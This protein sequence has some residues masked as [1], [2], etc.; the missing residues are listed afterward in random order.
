MEIS[1][2]LIGVIILLLIA[3]PVGYMIIS[4]G[5]VNKKVKKSVVQLSQSNG[6]QLKDID[7]IGNLVIG[8]DAI[9]RKLVYT[10]KKNPSDDFKI[11]DMEDV[12]DCHAKT[13]K[14][15][16][17]TLDWVGLEFIEKTGKKEIVFYDERADDEF[18]KDPFVCLQDAKRWEGTLRPLLKAS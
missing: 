6:I 7:I 18:S 9:S 17:K 8:V 11:V 15:S 16:D 12:K 14:Q 13:I 4:A 2:S 10:S 5:G 1:A 3:V